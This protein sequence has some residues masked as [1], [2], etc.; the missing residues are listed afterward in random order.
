[1]SLKVVHAF[2]ILSA[3]VLSDFFAFWALRNH[4][5]RKEPGMLGLSIC[6]FILSFALVIYLVWFIRKLKQPKFP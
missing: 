5:V 6:S 4:W 3:V 2:F 1:M